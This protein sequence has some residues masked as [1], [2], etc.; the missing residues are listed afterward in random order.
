MF[1][2]MVLTVCAVLMATAVYAVTDWDS[3][4]T[5]G[6]KKFELKASLFNDSVT[7]ESSFWGFDSKSTI[8]VRTLDFQISYGISESFD[9]GASFMS[10]KAFYDFEEMGEFE[11]EARSYLGMHLK[12]VLVPKT[13]AL[14]ADMAYML[15]S[16]ADAK[17]EARFGVHLTL[18]LSENI[19]THCAV[20]KPVRE[21][22]TTTFIIS[23]T[24]AYETDSVHLGAKSTWYMIEEKDN[25]VLYAGPYAS[26]NFTENIGIEALYQFMLVKPYADIDG[27]DLSGSKLQI[28]AVATF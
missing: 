25:N 11:G 28:S 20:Y 10:T 19:F 2:K 18:P 27:Y 3:A 4:N 15:E 7:E 6:E 23:N 9:L 12:G 22:N 26:V 16:E 24:L 21:N 17:F 13:M 14:S 5:I 8:S 1:R